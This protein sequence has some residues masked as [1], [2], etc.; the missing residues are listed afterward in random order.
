MSKMSDCN[1]INIGSLIFDEKIADIVESEGYNFP[2]KLLN[3]LL[4]SGSVPLNKDR[5]YSIMGMC[6]DS[7]PPITVKKVLGEKYFVID[8]RHRIASTIMNKGEVVPYKLYEP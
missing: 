5:L 4:D 8:G 7:I 1:Y 2:E 6:M 3:N